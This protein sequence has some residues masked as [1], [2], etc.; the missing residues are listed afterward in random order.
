MRVLTQFKSHLARTG[1]RLVSLWENSAGYLESLRQGA[2]WCLRP[3]TKNQCGEEENL[4]E[5]INEAAK[6]V[7]TQSLTFFVA[8]T[9]IAFSAAEVKDE[10][11]IFQDKLTLPIAN[12]SIP[13]EW[14]FLVAPTLLTGLH[15][16]ILLHE[17][18]LLE[19]IA[20]LPWKRGAVKTELFQPSISISGHFPREYL[21]LVGGLVSLSFWLIYITVPIFILAYLQMCALRF[22]NETVENGI[23]A[24]LVITL[25]ASIFFITVTKLIKRGNPDLWVISPGNVPVAG[26]R[27]LKRSIT[28]VLVLAGKLTVLAVLVGFTLSYIEMLRHPKSCVRES[29]F[30]KIFPFRRHLILTSISERFK[31]ASAGKKGVFNFRGRDLRCANFSG[32]ALVGADF[33]GANLAGAVFDGADLKEAH[34]SSFPWKKTNLIDASFVRTD[35]TRARFHDALLMETNF[36]RANLQEATLSGAD[37]SKARMFEANL[38]AAD[39]TRS[40]LRGAVL[41]NARLAFAKLDSASMELARFDGASLERA[42][43]KGAAPFG[44]SFRGARLRGASDLPLVGVDLQGAWVWGMNSCGALSEFPMH[45]NLRGLRFDPV[46]NWQPFLEEI[47]MAARTPLLRSTWARMAEPLAV[48][49]GTSAP[50]CIS[51]T[52]DIQ[53]ARDRGWS[54]YLKEK[55][56]LHD[57]PGPGSFFEELPAQPVLT[58][59]E[60]LSGLIRELIKKACFE[61]VEPPQRGFKGSSLLGLLEPRA[62]EEMGRFGQLLR[63][64]LQSISCEVLARASP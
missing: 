36:R 10:F 44:A 35:L 43:F 9:Y 2:L 53:V 19:K 29:K 6:S 58:E 11:F 28:R 34:F 21:P 18:Y 40:R 31:E 26:G 62:H 4:I 56:V 50:T 42:S 57:R 39:L 3:P 64:S 48:P 52:D 25:M 8:A 46:D 13:V 1:Q 15:L 32:V 59:E 20:A 5:S 45:V 54:T 7:G 23:N 51:D 17:Y 24:C 49:G 61:E 37:L 14:F 55:N 38:V 41:R 60:Y 30:L 12:A 33:R 22:R 47:R 16:M 27:G 63:Q